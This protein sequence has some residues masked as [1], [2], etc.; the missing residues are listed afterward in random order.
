[1]LGCPAG[2]GKGRLQ[3]HRARPACQ[4]LCDNPT[5][6][7]PGRPV[8]F[9]KWVFYVD[10]STLF[11]G[12]E[13]FA[14]TGGLFLQ[15]AGPFISQGR[16]ID[17]R[18]T[19]MGDYFFSSARLAFGSGCPAGL[20]KG[21]WTTLLLCKWEG[22]WESS[23]QWAGQGCKRSIQAHLCTGLQRKANICNVGPSPRLVN[24]SLL[25]LFANSF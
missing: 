17:E 1:M 18:F 10:G 19:C 22:S 3:G 23:C 5:G 13:R 21:I 2:L 6:W 16:R 7:E 24:L 20:S 11:C 15:A 25:N 4:I 8:L 12:S 9:P 14:Y